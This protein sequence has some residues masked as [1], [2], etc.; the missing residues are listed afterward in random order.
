MEIWIHEPLPAELENDSSE[1]FLEEGGKFF[2]LNI[3]VDS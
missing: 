1:F 2:F 3:H